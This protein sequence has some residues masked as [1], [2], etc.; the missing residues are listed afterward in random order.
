LAI[1][2]AAGQMPPRSLIKM[3]D[4]ACITGEL[5]ASFLGRLRAYARKVRYDRIMGD[6]VS[7][8]GSK[9]GWTFAEPAPT[10]KV[11]C[12]KRQGRLR[13]HYP[14]PAS[15]LALA[16]ISGNPYYHRK[17]IHGIVASRD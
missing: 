13:L 16:S 7:T 4:F 5:A 17:R 14:L 9:G 2:E 12:E 6:E 3:E 10:P 15:F 8:R 1:S 11:C